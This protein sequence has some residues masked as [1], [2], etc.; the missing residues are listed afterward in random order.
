M[1]SGELC[2]GE[3]MY[4]KPHCVVAPAISCL[5]ASCTSLFPVVP[6]KSMSHSSSDQLC[7]HV[8]EGSQDLVF[9]NTCV[10]VVSLVYC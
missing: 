7:V 4:R 1:K 2:G 6:R 5:C 10:F 3:G 9:V 8:S